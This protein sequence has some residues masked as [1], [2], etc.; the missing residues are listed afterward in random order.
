MGGKKPFKR[1][2]FGTFAAHRVKRG[3]N[4]M[5]SAKQPAL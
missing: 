3:V 5:I 1:F 4:E 2:F